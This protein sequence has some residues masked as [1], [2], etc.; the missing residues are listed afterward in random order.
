MGP[1]LPVH[2]DNKIYVVTLKSYDDLDGF[3]SDME[4]DGYQL[5]MKRPISRNTQ[6]YMTSAQALALREDSRVLDV[7]RRPL[8]LPGV[9]IRPTYMGNNRPFGGSFEFR[10]SDDGNAYQGLDTQWGLLHSSGS[11]TKR[12]KNVFG[13]DTGQVVFTDDIDV[14]N[15]GRHVDVVIVDEPVSFDCGEWNSDL[16][17]ANRFVQY[18]WY[19]QLNQYVTSIDDDGTTLPNPPYAN[20]FDN[21]TAAD[22]HGIH[23]AGTVAGRTYGWAREANIYSLQVLN[24]TLGTPCN[25]ML[26]FDYLRAFH[27]HKPINTETGQRN[28]TV[29]NH[30]WGYGMNWWYSFERAITTEDIIG[31]YHRGTT[32]NSSNPGPNGWTMAGIEKDF[33]VG[34]WVFGYPADNSAIRADLEDAVEDGVIV[35]GAAGNDDRWGAKNEDGHESYLQDWNNYI[36]MDIPGYG[37]YS[38]WCDR[39]SSP[40]NGKGCIVVGAI[41]NESDFRRADFS[42]YGPLVDVWAP[43]YKIVSAWPNPNNIQGSYNG[44][45]VQ[46]TK[47]GGANWHWPI[48]GTSMASPQVCGIAALLAT[49]KERFTNSDVLAFIQQKGIR[50]DMT[51]EISGGLFDDSTASGAANP[52]YGNLRDADIEIDAVN[53]RAT[54]GHIYGWYNGD[55]HGHRRPEASFQNAQM[56]PRTNT[57]NRQ[58]VWPTPKTFNYTVSASGS[59]AYIVTGDDRIGN[60]YS[61]TNNP[62]LNVWIGDVLNFNMSAPGHPLWVKTVA[63]TGAANNVV[64]S[65]L[66]G[67]G[68]ANG[69]SVV[70]DTSGYDEGT[71]YYQC[72]LHTPM[73][74]EINLIRPA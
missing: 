23:V 36:A 41:S 16:N 35:I 7:Q 32:Y 22:L 67:G 17:G 50:N 71:Y 47:Y 48:S 40:C 63:G 46:D 68:T 38:W 66:T 53:P 26:V 18:D 64:P 25:E 31:I 9:E 74:G 10:K 59:G 43:G 4:S 21:A 6:Y 69:G 11:G 56:Y 34:A 28:P 44:V 37:T 51:W 62:T 61:N 55:L 19:G 49:G 42:N 60:S 58:I 13:Q 15:D 73:Y 52:T 1:D 54:S 70:W 39:G 27:R 72:E 14:F 29:T 3:Y 24:A 8:D 33:G 57:Y 20:Y 5:H 30:S 65:G 2:T 45:G 12:R